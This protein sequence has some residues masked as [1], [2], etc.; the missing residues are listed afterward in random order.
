M[1]A[2]NRAKRKVQGQITQSVLIIAHG[3]RENNMS[4]IIKESE[5][6]VIDSDAKALWALQKIKEARADRDTWVAWYKQKIKEITEQ[7]DFDTMN[8]ERMLADYFATVPHKTTKTQESYTLPGGKLILKKQNPEYTRDD[9]TVIEWLKVNKMPQFVKV[10][11]ELDWAG[12][13][14]ATGVFEGNVVTEDGEII[15]GITVTDREAKFV[16]EV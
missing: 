2:T 5:G 15:P 10:K 14:D 9:K 11:E 1:A 4:E 13:K 3:E 16:V 12:L 6:F 8:L 7:T